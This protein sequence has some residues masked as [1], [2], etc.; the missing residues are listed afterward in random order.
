MERS[1]EEHEAGGYEEQRT[2]KGQVDR[3]AFR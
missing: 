3:L 2:H 1:F